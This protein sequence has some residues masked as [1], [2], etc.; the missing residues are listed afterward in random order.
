MLVRERWMLGDDTITGWDLSLLMTFPEE[1]FYQYFGPRFEI[2]GKFWLEKDIQHASCHL[3]LITTRE[4]SKVHNTKTLISAFQRHFYDFSGEKNA[5]ELCVKCL[6]IFMPLPAHQNSIS[7]LGL[8]QVQPFQLNL[9]TQPPMINHD[10]LGLCLSQRS[11]HVSR[12]AQRFKSLCKAD[13]TRL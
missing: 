10:L 4:K 13:I 9:S 6:C 3:S 8:K 5:T 1:M 12:S 2:W 7:T 11:S